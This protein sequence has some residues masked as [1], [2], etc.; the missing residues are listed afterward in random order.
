V[1]W[2]AATSSPHLRHPRAAGDHRR[3]R[4]NYGAEIAPPEI[5]AS[6]LF[7]ADSA[8]VVAV[9]EKN[10]TFRRVTRRI[11]IIW[12]STIAR[13]LAAFFCSCH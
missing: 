10:G 7:K 6:P 13:F 4:A 11:W 9:A 3:S 1:C 2:T 5:A 12:D 8:T